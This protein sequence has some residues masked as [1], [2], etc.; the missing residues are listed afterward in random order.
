M[1]DEPLHDSKEDSESSGS[2]PSIDAPSVKDDVSFFM[3]V[4]ACNRI[5]L[6]LVDIN[7]GL[8]IISYYI[9]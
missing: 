7:D 5:S 3:Y 6:L 9:L 1:S 2:N 4:S 8:L